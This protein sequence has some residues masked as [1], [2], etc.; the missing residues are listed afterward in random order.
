LA[1]TPEPGGSG[2]LLDHTTILW[3]NE[4]RKGND[5]S[6]DNIPFVLVANGRGFQ[7]GRSLNCPLVPRNRLLLS[8]AHAFGD[9]IKQFGN[10]DYCDDGPLNNLMNS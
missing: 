2:S 5:H 3:T 1:E 4:L 9:P 6:H 10:S 8:L 7:M